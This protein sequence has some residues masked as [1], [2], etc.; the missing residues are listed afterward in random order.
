MRTKKEARWATPF[1][2]FSDATRNPTKLKDTTM[3]MIQLP[4]RQH[5]K[6]KMLV[7]LILIFFQFFTLSCAYAQQAEM[8]AIEAS[9]KQKASKAEANLLKQLFVHA[10]RDADVQGM[11]EST[12][13]ITLQANGEDEIRRIYRETYIP[14][15]QL[16]NKDAD[17]CE[18]I[19]IADPDGTNGWEFRCE[20]T[21]DRAEIMYISVTVLREEKWVVASVRFANAQ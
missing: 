19:E 3:K 20:L 8:Q 12:S 21:N 17:E 11:I 5:L 2:P 13:L 16:F 6:I 4:M 18:A 14:R 1:Y 10:A 9:M 7:I 15:F